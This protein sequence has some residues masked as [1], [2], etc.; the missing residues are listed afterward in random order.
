MPMTTNLKILFILC[1]IGW[2][3]SEAISEGMYDCGL[4]EWSKVVQA[5]MIIFPFLIIYFNKQKTTWYL[6]AIY[7]LF[8]LMFFDP[9]YNLVRGNQL[10]A[11]GTTS[12]IY[13]KYICPILHTSM[14]WYGMLFL[15]VVTIFI[16][17]KNET[18]R[19]WIKKVSL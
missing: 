9:A 6:P 18:I 12:F 13:D 8:R 7:I 5:G 16:Y 15:L 14:V 11:C 1:L 19:T 2:I 17:L 10:M 3:L 4:K